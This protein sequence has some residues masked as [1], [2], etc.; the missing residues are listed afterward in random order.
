MDRNFRKL[1]KIG[2]LCAVL[3]SFSPTQSKAEGMIFQTSSFC[4][5][6]VFFGHNS[7]WLLVCLS[8]ITPYMVTDVV[9]LPF[10]MTVGT[11]DMQVQ[12][13]EASQSDSNVTSDVTP[14]TNTTKSKD[15]PSYKERKLKASLFR[16]IESDAYAVRVGDR[17]QHPLFVGL[18]EETRKL[19]NFDE[20]EA[21]KFVAE[22]VIQINAQYDQLLLD[23]ESK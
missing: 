13:P 20:Q 23:E 1:A 9:Y 18:V 3:S 17:P 2:L 6:T 10:D 15:A 21:T 8:V 14:D 4:I 16:L 12:N 22:R 19:K 11:Y 7:N 5:E